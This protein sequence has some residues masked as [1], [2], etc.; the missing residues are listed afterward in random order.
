[1]EHISCSSLH[2]TAIVYGE[3]RYFDQEDL[4]SHEYLPLRSSVSRTNS[5]GLSAPSF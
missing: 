5:F 2:L 1:M 3:E 4:L